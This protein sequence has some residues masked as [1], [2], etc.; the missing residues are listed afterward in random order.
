[1][2]GKADFGTAVAICWVKRRFAMK[3]KKMETGK[4][5]LDES[6]GAYKDPKVVEG[7]IAETAEI[8]DRVAPVLAM[9]D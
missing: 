3:H 9:K 4:L 5:P 6:A 1:M 7:A 2:Y 8:V